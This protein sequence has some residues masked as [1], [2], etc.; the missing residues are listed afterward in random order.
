MSE[1]HHDQLLKVAKS[2][3]AAVAV[4][5]RDAW[6]SI[7]ASYNIVEDPIGSRPH[8]SGV[9]DGREGR[10]GQ[11]PLQRFYDTFISPNEIRF[12]VAQDVVL[13]QTV[14]REL[15][16]ELGM[17]DKVKAEVPMHAFYDMVQEG[18]EVKVCRLAAHWELMPMVLQVMGK[19]LPG[20]MAMLSLGWRMVRIQRLGGVLGFCLG[21][22]GIHGRG[23]ELVADFSR[24][25]ETK[26]SA[27]LNSIFHSERSE[28]FV[29]SVDPS[30]GQAV[31]LHHPAKFLVGK[32]ITIATSSMISAGYCI[33]CVIDV[34]CDGQ[35]HHGIGMF[36]FNARSRRLDRV[37]LFWNQ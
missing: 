35:A 33:T 7:F 2:S 1:S 20:M 26:N 21:F 15:V 13:G 34:Q 22:R 24:A 25:V 29:P 28:I 18:G 32:D 3:P 19:G 9:F 12:R 36:E 4:K 16:I 23:K 11:G 8:V 31:S 5:D 14:C 37:K 10:R 6:M 27:W 30:Q 17:N